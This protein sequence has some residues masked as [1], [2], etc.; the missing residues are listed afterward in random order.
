MMDEESGRHRNKLEA[1]QASLVVEE[2]NCHLPEKRV[3]VNGNKTV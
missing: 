1:S 2:N 3:C